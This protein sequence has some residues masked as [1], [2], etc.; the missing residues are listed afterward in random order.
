M[1]LLD[2]TVLI[3]Y[4]NAAENWQ[5]EKLDQ[6]IGKEIVVLGGYILTEVPKGF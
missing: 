2:S 5:V 3:D 1:I 4:F 6:I